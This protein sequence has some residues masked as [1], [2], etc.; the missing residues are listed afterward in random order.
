MLARM[1][2]CLLTAAFLLLPS[3]ARADAMPSCPPGQH[4]VHNPATPG[5]GHHG[6]GHCEYGCSVAAVGAGH[7]SAPW[8]AL[9]LGLVVLRRR[10]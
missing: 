8:A 5:S 6:G 3:F 1:K 10:R 2:R 7:G 4:L 9:A